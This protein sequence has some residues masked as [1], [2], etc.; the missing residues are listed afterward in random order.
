MTRKS[1]WKSKLAVRAAGVEAGRSTKAGIGATFI[2]VYADDTVRTKIGNKVTITGNDVSIYAEKAKVDWSDYK[3]TFEFSHYIK[4]TKDEKPDENTL[5]H[6]NY[7]SKSSEKTNGEGT[8]NTENKEPE[9]KTIE[10]TKNLKDT[11]IHRTALRACDG[12]DDS[13]QGSYDQRSQ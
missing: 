7:N 9:K 4:F 11:E 13:R 10:V 6:I 5:V 8:Q 3:S 2:N 12:R 1:W